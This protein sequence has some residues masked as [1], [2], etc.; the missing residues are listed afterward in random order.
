M[1]RGTMETPKT[2]T[3]PVGTLT[4]IQ[5]PKFPVDNLIYE[6]REFTIWLDEKSLDVWWHTAGSYD[7]KFD[8]LQKRSEWGEIIARQTE[9]E[10]LPTSHLS[11]ESKRGFRFQVGNGILLLFTEKFE[12]ARKS[13]DSAE[14]FYRA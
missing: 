1:G 9:L 7:Q 5:R 8:E 4:E 10:S 3:L 12:H 14:A 11:E 6:S 13:M 2:G